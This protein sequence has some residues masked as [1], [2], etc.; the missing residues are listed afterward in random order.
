ML[1]GV[2]TK[3]CEGGRLRMP[4]NAKNPAFLVKAVELGLIGGQ[5]HFKLHH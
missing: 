5:I 1:K 3:I 2:E 4:V